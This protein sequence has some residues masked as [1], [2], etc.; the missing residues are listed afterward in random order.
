MAVHG[1]Y[2]S[3]EIYFG[4]QKYTTWSKA[5]ELEWSHSEFFRKAYKMQ[6]VCMIGIL[7]IQ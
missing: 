4:I 5:V 2:Y 7:T 1:A 3:M 6:I